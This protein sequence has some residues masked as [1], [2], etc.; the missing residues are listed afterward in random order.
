MGEIKTK[1]KKSSIPLMDHPVLPL[2]KI[3][4]SLPSLKTGGGEGKGRSL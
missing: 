3:D 4:I 2:F 1:G